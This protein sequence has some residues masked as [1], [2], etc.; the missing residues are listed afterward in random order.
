MQEFYST[1]RQSKPLWKESITLRVIFGNRG[2]TLRVY[3]LVVLVAAGLMGAATHQILQGDKIKEAA[4]QN[5]IS[6]LEKDKK[7]VQTLLQRKEHEKKQALALA[8]SRSEELWDEIHD[9]DQ[10]MDKLWEAV[11]QHPEHGKKSIQVSRG[12]R[13]FNTYRLKHRYDQIAEELRDKGGEMKN[14]QTATN[15]FRKEK[16]RRA[17]ERALSLSTLPSIYPCQASISSPFGYRMHPVLG[18]AKF[19]SGIDLS[20][21]YGQSIVATAAGRVTCADWLG[22]YGMAVT[23]DHGSGLSTLY[24]HCS[25]LHVSTGQYVKKGQLIASVGSTGMSTGPHCHYE[26]HKDGTQ[27]DPMPYMH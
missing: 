26:V 10:Q 7:R 6:E 3:P 11:G 27:V 20:A 1:S 14:L 24:G 19:H 12:P 15:A 13:R 18:Y 22:G 8:E 25:Q 2:R 5:K 4:Y 21:G 17:E 16:I 9:R 23:I